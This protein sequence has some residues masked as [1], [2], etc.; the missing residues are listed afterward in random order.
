MLE[1]D[2]YPEISRG[3][4]T[5]SAERQHSI[6]KK[7]KF[8]L[9]S[10]SQHRFIVRLRHM[11]A[12]KHIRVSQKREPNARGL[13]ARATHQAIVPHEAQHQTVESFKRKAMMDRC[14][15]L[16]CNFLEDIPAG[17]ALRLQKKLEDEE[18]RS[19][20]CS[21]KR[22]RTPPIGRVSPG[23]SQK[24]WS[25]GSF[26]AGGERGDLPWPPHPRRRQFRHHRRRRDSP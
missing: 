6:N 21:I 5:S 14:E 18:R 3:H 20:R 17:K 11:A 7:S 26:D 9:P 13:V 12:Y 8:S 23:S 1:A 10:M 2:E 25:K 22:P 15:A 24:C 19:L 4:D 16:N